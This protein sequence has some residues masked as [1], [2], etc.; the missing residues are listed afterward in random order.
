MAD[1]NPSH[2]GL[3]M[4]LAEG[5]T[6]E[7]LRDLA[8]ELKGAGKP[9]GFAYL[10]KTARARWAERGKLSAPVAPSS[11]PAAARAWDLLLSSDGAVQ[12]S[13]PRIHKALQACGGWTPVR[14]R[15]AYDAPKLKAAFC[16]AY[17]EAA[18]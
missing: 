1:V 14:M 3:L 16:R 17:L 6:P 7:S 2:A 10:I 8:A 18:R 5:I 13:D 15:T 11:D 12:R 4:A 9:T